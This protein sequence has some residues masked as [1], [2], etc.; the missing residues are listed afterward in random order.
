V[1]G[2]VTST[3]SPLYVQLA[4]ALQWRFNTPILRMAREYSNNS[5]QCGS[6]SPWSV[7]SYS[8]GVSGKPQS[9]LAQVQ[10]RLGNLDHSSAYCSDVEP[11]IS[12]MHLIAHTS[13][14]RIKVIAMPTQEIGVH[15]AGADA[16]PNYHFSRSVMLRGAEK[17]QM[18]LSLSSISCY[19]HSAERS[20]GGGGP[21]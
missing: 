14:L 15:G 10:R 1:A 5:P 9:C 18:M 12:Q 8:G 4:D 2:I 17:E 6:S 21:A 20:P 16:P 19:R 11:I 3:G 13:L 7:I